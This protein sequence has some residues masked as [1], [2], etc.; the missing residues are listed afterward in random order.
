MKTL[1]IVQACH[2]APPALDKIGRKLGGQDAAGMG[3]PPRHRLPA[4]RPGRRAAGRHAQRARAGPAGSADVEVFVGSEPDALAGSP[5][6]WPGMPPRHRADLR[7]QSVRRLRS[8][9][10]AREHGRERFRL[11]LCQLCLERRPTVDRLAAGPVCRVVLG[12]GHRRRRTAGDRSPRPPGSHPLFVQP[13]A[14]VRRPID[15]IAAESGRARTCNCGS[16]AGKIGTIS[17]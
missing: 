9:R 6:S 17:R 1:G 11:R 12:Q 5:R 2:V 7:R 4:A 3:R 15:R 16:T 10:P 14:A 13:P 8:D